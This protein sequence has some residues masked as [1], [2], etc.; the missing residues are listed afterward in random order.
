MEGMMGARHMKRIDITREL[1]TAPVY[2]GDPEPRLE[3]MSRIELGDVCNTSLLHACLHTGT[4]LDAPRH[5]V[6][7]GADTEQALLEACVGDC[8]V[9]AFDG[10]LLGAQAEALLGRVR[11][12]LLF[13]G[14]T[15]ISPSAAFVLSDAGFRLVGVEGPS[16]SP[17]ECEAAVHRQLL[18]SG[19]VL[20]E[21]LD[22]SAAEPGGYFL[23]AAPLKI[24]GG[25]GSPVRAV[26]LTE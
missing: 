1:L 9:V 16:V 13:K 22:L 8:T 23:F 24:R 5:F 7:E 26:L 3:A 11:R 20:L 17:A 14:K 2:P 6:P 21:G 12:R 25:D 15:L 10:L 19:M 18:G 4:H